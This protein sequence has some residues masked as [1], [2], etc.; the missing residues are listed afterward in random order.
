[1]TVYCSEG[2]VV[3]LSW[4]VALHYESQLN[5]SL[6]MWLVYLC[7]N[8]SLFCFGH[9]FDQRVME[10]QNKVVNTDRMSSRLAS[11]NQLSLLSTHDV[12]EEKKVEKPPTQLLEE[13]NSSGSKHRAD[14]ERIAGT[15]WDRVIVNFTLRSCFFFWCSV[16]LPWTVIFV[17][18]AQRHE[19]Y[20]GS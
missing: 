14:F 16:L 9:W 13:G 17:V 5:R 8:P 12:M 6:H 11:T 3:V 4:K 2:C 1:M 20:Q 19:L 18:E 10:M 7:L 15:S